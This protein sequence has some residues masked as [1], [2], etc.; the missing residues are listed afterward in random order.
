MMRAG[1]ET[2]TWRLHGQIVRR[3]SARVNITLGAFKRRNYD[4]RISLYRR[5]VRRTAKQSQF[6]SYIHI[7]HV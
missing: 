1:V 5:N 4:D 2:N 3:Q 6:F 7:L